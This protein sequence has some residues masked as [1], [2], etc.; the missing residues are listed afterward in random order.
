MPSRVRCA[1]L[2]CSKCPDRTLPMSS[3]LAGHTAQG[4][5]C[6]DLG[7]DHP[8]AGER[9][10][11]PLRD[12]KVNIRR[13]SPVYVIERIWHHCS[14]FFC[15]CN[16][17]DIPAR[18]LLWQRHWLNLSAPVKS[19]I[20]KAS[21][22]VAFFFFFFLGL[23][24]PGRYIAHC[25]IGDGAVEMLSVRDLGIGATINVD[26]VPLSQKYLVAVLLGVAICENPEPSNDI[27]RNHP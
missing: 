7:C 5:V 4:C 6:D 22:R 3:R 26:D 10:D 15:R 24:V 1:H 19:T 9:V 16:A 2:L 11:S 8:I 20:T 25:P 23:C 18:I 14:A 27:L 21:R 13:H 17:G 12:L